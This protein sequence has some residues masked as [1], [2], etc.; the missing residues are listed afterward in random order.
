MVYMHLSYFSRFFEKE[1]IMISV[2]QVKPPSHT[3]TH[4]HTLTHTLTHP[5][6]H[7]HTLTH[8]TAYKSLIP[9]AIYNKGI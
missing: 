5:H 2:A 7:T 9:I 4:T 8:T 3:H 6:T 1:S